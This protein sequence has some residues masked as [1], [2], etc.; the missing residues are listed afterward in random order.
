MGSRRQAQISVSALIL[1]VLLASELAAQTRA[2]QRIDWQRQQTGLA[3]YGIIGPVQRPGVYQFA[4]N[5]CLLNDL[6]RAAGGPTAAVTGN[7]RVVRQGR[8][9]QGTFL[10]P[11]SH[12]ELL[13]G[14]LVVLGE[15]LRES[16]RV[17]F[18]PKLSVLPA[19]GNLAPAAS[20]P[21]DTVTIALLNVLP[22]PVIAQVPAEQATVNGIS[23]WLRQSPE[24]AQRV[25]LLFNA[26]RPSES[27]S[28]DPRTGRLA[29]GSV[30]VF[31]PG[32]IEM[33]LL[34]PLPEPLS[35]AATE[36]SLVPALEP[37]VIP[38]T[39]QDGPGL[40]ERPLP[41][42]MAPGLTTSPRD[43]ALPLLEDPRAL[44][45][46]AFPTA[47]SP[48]SGGLLAP[49]A[50]GPSLEKTVL[51]TG[52]DATRPA[53][54][55]ALPPPAEFSIPAPPVA[56]PVIANRGTVPQRTAPIDR[57]NRS[58]DSAARPPATPPTDSRVLVAIMALGVFAAAAL[59]LLRL[60]ARDGRHWPASLSRSSTEAPVSAAASS[61]PS[62]DPLELLIHNRLQVI[63]EPL[64]LPAHLEFQGHP[65]MERWFR[66]DAAHVEPSGSVRVSAPHYPL[67]N[68]SLPK[69]VHASGPSIP[70]PH[71]G[72]SRRPGV[73][74][75][76]ESVAEREQQISD[77]PQST[78][79]AVS[80]TAPEFVP[81]PDAAPQPSTNRRPTRRR[82][83]EP[84]SEPTLLDRVLV[85]VQK[86]SR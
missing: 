82:E 16:E 50:P 8:A 27:P 11:H 32:S 7:V 31:A 41:N 48:Q 5:H 75:K 21:R 52:P 36:R 46:P 85:R 10:S 77:L 63:E 20:A 83:P 17:G 15:N 24:T 14:D 37:A 81:I 26:V 61:P 3:Y 64:P 65:A 6:I 79:P 76:P 38:R 34:P 35:A 56:N 78:A 54:Q 40:D 22:R 73:E 68:T 19:Q 80:A 72:R 39:P 59:I 67:P 86:V 23:A 9:G 55:L 57:E 47:P 18:G 69:A 74:R 62:V 12:Y 51:P 30:L 84:T 58:A 2:L 29:S 1:G 42:L 60:A 25:N 13:P 33:K 70:K 44:P 28:A 53:A 49:D 43:A 45:A 66:P 71:F 4:A